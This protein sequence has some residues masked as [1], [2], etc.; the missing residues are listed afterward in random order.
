MTA[1]PFDNAEAAFAPNEPRPEPKGEPGRELA[2][3]DAPG[4][5]DLDEESYH[6]DPCPEPA[7][8]SSL[9]KLLARKSPRHAYTASPRL[10]PH[11]EDKNSG[12]FDKGKTFHKLIL[13]EGAT[14]ETFAADNWTKAGNAGRDFKAEC[15]KRGSIPLLEKDLAKAE[16]MVRAVR[17]QMPIWEELAYSMSGGLPERTLVWVE[18]TPFGPIWCRARLD[19]LPAHGDL[20]P[21]WKWTTTGAGPDEWGAKT[22]WNLDADFQA[23]FYRRGIQACLGQDAHLFFAV[24]EESEPFALATHRLTPEAE[25]LA[26]RDVQRAIN[27]WGLCL[28]KNRWPG[29]RAQMSWQDPPVWKERVLLEREERGDQEPDVLLEQIRRIPEMIERGRGAAAEGENVDVFGLAPVQ[30]AGK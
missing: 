19:W 21:D 16:E 3:V 4:V 25:A 17:A 5:Y 13:G 28:S 30:E 2:T 8:S 14:L 23:A 27:V 22:L 11:Y 9:G 1:N 6:A 24:A 7:L 15:R 12:N 26:A 10:N 20:F 18:E 29:Y